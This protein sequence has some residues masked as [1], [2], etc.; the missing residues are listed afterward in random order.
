MSEPLIMYRADN[1]EWRV[2]QVECPNGLHPANDADGKT[3]YENTHFK[4]SK[5]AWKRLQREAQAW[6]SLALGNQRRIKGDLEE[7][8][9]NIIK[10]ST[11]LDNVLK[12]KPKELEE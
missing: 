8:N 10:A 2:I 6:L 12:R 7:A 3:I 4:T 9:D 1:D 11:A 5:E